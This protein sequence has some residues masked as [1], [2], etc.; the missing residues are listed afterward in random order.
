MSYLASVC[1]WHLV[2]FGCTESLSA[3]FARSDTVFIVLTFMTCVITAACLLKKFYYNPWFCVG[4]NKPQ[5]AMFDTTLMLTIASH[6]FRIAMLMQTRSTAPTALVPTTDAM[7]MH[8]STVVMLDLIFYVLGAITLLSMVLSVAQVIDK[9]TELYVEFT[10]HGIVVKPR[11]F[12]TFR[13][14]AM[15]ANL[16]LFINLAFF[17]SSATAFIQNRRLNYLFF[18]A[19]CCV[20]SAPMMALFGGAVIRKIAHLNNLTTTN[21]LFTRTVAPRGEAMLGQPSRA[22]DSMAVV[23]DVLADAAL[24]KQKGMAQK[25]KALLNLQVVVYFTTCLYLVI[26]CVGILYVVGNEIPT[27]Y[28]TQ[29]IIKVVVDTLTWIC[30]L[31]LPLYMISFGI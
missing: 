7:S 15:L 5:W 14:L 11:Y 30:P 13:G 21:S 9:S 26:G 28:Q 23:R 12:I 24:H 10:F 4:P 16:V 27:S 29:F 22:M 25:Q 18:A 2:Y 1:D 20:V 3:L 6:S 17:S 19:M 31:L 8:M